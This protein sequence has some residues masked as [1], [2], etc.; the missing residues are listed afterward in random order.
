MSAEPSPQGDRELWI[1]DS[2]C[3][4]LST[5][6]YDGHTAEIMNTE[7]LNTK[8]T[9]PDQLEFI[10]GKGG[11]PCIAIDNGA[12][13]ALISIYGGQVLGYQPA[14]T[15]EEILFLSQKAHYEEG[16]AIKGGIPICWP[17]FGA[18]PEGKGP[19][20]GF[21][22]NRMWNVIKTEGSNDGVTKVTLGFSDSTA[23]K[24][25]WP[26]TFELTLEISVGQSLGLVL[27]T[28]NTGNQP[29][30]IT[31]ALHTYFSVDEINQVKIAG[32]DGVN[33]LDKVDNFKQKQQTGDVTI[34]GE[35]DRI[36]TEAPPLLMIDDAARPRRIQIESSGNK[37]AVIWNPWAEITASM[38]DLEEDAYQHF[39]CV[40]TANAADDAIEIAAGESHRLTAN[41]RVV[42]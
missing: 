18:D 13:C 35:V 39:I 14:G 4:T 6:V 10:A 41:Y 8:F 28:H 31:Q 1:L 36:Y 42:D 34:A 19:A 2:L 37:T 24:K 20:H 27:T 17:W 22:R 25:I 33:Y 9:V 15:T 12:A 38:A 23:T 32:L 7:E 16:K 30:T 11:L 5:T 29:F 3:A 26:H 21:A 40:E